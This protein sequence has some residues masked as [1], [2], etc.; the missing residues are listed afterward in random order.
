MGEI[1]I[2]GL[3]FLLLG[4]IVII[5]PIAPISAEPTIIEI[6]DTLICLI[7]SWLVLDQKS[8]PLLSILFLCLLADILWMRPI[9]LWPM[10]ILLAS[11]L[12]RHYRLRI[13][14]QSTLVKFFCFLLF[15]SIINTGVKLLSLV[16]ALKPLDF[17]IWLKYF[18]FTV[19]LFPIVNF[20]LECTIFRRKQTLK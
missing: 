8:A 16:V 14:N 2:K 19:L 20:C 9:G 6:P 18:L 13:V 10:F 11:E 12:V 7:F 4:A 5:I 15:F 17:M 1:F 3:Y